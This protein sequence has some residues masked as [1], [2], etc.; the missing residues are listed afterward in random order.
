MKCENER[1]AI[2]IEDVGVLGVSADVR[3][4]VETLA[5]ASETIVTEGTRG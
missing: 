1:H 2:R 4:I 5:R 3:I